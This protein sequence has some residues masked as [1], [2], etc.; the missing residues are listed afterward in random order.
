M[1]DRDDDQDSI[2]AVVAAAGAGDQAAW[3]N[4]VDRY[5]PLLIS[6]IRRFRLTT[7]E[8]EDV[9]Q[10]VWLRLVE[11]L[12]SLREPRALPM[13]LITT[14]RRESLR[15]LSTERRSSPHDP[16]EPTWSNQVT[17]ETAWGAAE[18]P[19]PG[20]ELIRAGRQQALLAGLAELN[21]RQRELLILLVKDPPLSYAEISARTGVPVGAIGPTRARAV[22]RL[23]HSAAV[24]AW[25]DTSYEGRPEHPG[26]GRRRRA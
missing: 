19:E 7:S 2:C 20:D 22:D 26:S 15:Y 11:H 24:Q 5:T 23:R 8:A 6:V 16:L 25:A 18:P 10:T 17:A 4:I 1:D 21:D 3:N 12:G 14:G 9:A 13:W